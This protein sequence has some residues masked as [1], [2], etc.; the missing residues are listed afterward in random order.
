MKFGKN[1]YLPIGFTK[2][3][4]K[5][6]YE[7]QKQYSLEEAKDMAIESLSEKLEKSIENTDDICDKIIKTE[8]NADY[9]EVFMTYEVIESIGE[10]KK[11]EN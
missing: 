6:E 9:I 10:D 3:T 4:N 7:E 8:E 2:V 5:E 1:F 11:M